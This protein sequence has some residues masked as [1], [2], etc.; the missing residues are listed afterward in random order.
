MIDAKK[1]LSSLA[2]SCLAVMFCNHTGAQKCPRSQL[3]PV[4]FV[5]GYNIANT[6]VGCRIWGFGGMKPSVIKAYYKL[7]TEENFIMWIITP[8]ST[9]LINLIIEWRDSTRARLC[10][11]MHTTHSVICL[12]SNDTVGL[13]AYLVYG[14]DVSDVFETIVCELLQ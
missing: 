6:I 4:V 10:L 8:F 1:L 5:N 9:I 13:L 3:R 2:I 14:L 12:D 7:L 11:I